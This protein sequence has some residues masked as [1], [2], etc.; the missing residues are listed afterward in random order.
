MSAGI[1]IVVSTLVATIPAVA[2]VFQLVPMSGY[3]WVLA[4]GLALAQLVAVEIEKFFL[5]RK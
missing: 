3:H 5:N 4:I 1:S 2:T